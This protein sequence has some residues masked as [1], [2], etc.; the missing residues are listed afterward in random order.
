MYKTKLSEIKEK[1]NTDFEQGLTNEE[2]SIRR[3]KFGRNELQKSKK[4][5]FIKKFLAQFKDTMIIVLIIAGFVSLFINLETG[6]GLFEPI[7]IFV[8]VISNALIGSIQE[9]RA[10]KALNALKNIT[11]KT[12]KVFRGH[13]NG[14]RTHE[15][16]NHYA[17]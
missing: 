15:P 2:V 5:S 12:A 10:E 3:E 11:S 14:D 6:S 8:L 4:H 16:S 13:H 7:L 17:A 1:L 9:A